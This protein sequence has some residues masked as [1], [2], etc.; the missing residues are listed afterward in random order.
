MLVDGQVYEEG[1]KEAPA[2]SEDPLVQQFLTGS[3]QGPMKV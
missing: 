2:H 1:D 3:L